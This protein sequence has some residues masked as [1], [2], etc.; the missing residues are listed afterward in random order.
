MNLQTTIDRTQSMAS[1]KLDEAAYFFEQ[2][3]FQDGD[4]D[5]NSEYRS[6]SI[7]LREEGAEL[8]SAVNH[9]KGVSPE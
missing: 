8:I 9:L 3:Q 5:L 4:E 6:I 7:S 1:Q 2:S